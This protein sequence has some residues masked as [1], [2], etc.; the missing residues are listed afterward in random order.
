MSK[1]YKIKKI[2]N[3]NFTLVINGKDERILMGRGIAFG[4]RINDYVDEDKIEKVFVFEDEN[5][6]NSFHSLMKQVGKADFFEV[7]ANMVQAIEKDSD[8]KVSTAMYMALSDHI[9]LALERKKNNQELSNKL[10]NEIK[11]FYP[12]EF[13]LGK[14]AVQSI[15]EQT[16][17]HLSEDEAGFLALHLI[18][19]SEENNQSNLEQVKAVTDIVKI[20]EDYFEIE[21]NQD[22]F[23]YQRL[24]THLKYFAARVF[25]TP[26]DKDQSPKDDFFYRVSKVQYPK[27]HKCVDL[28]AQYLDYNYHIL[29]KTDEKG[30]LIIHLC[31]LLK[32][33]EK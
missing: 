1:K 27:I 23:Y 32:R 2:I 4:K 28:I 26:D 12:N 16:G 31:G 33:K 9:S 17:V 15:K 5:Q 13:E 25:K 22:D 24:M 18:N 14:K 20:I 21:L 8:V 6:A 7:I 29:M 11:R 19:A 30:F 3:N 10:L